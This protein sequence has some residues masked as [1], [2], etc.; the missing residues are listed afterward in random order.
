ML[1]LANRASPQEFVS[2]RGVRSASFAFS[3]PLGYYNNGAPV[4]AETQSLSPS[5]HVPGA[6]SDAD[7]AASEPVANAGRPMATAPEL[8]VRE[9]NSLQSCHVMVDRRKSAC[10]TLRGRQFQG[11]ADV[12]DAEDGI[13]GG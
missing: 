1:A 5:Q 9:P 6:T 11:A 4:C 7:T 2:Q 12:A 3:I 8:P 10:P 13:C